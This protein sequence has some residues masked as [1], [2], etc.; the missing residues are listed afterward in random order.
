LALA[1]K[2]DNVLMLSKKTDSNPTNAHSFCC[3]T[4]TLCSKLAAE[5]TWS[6]YK[7]PNCFS[8]SD[9]YSIGSL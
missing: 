7:C 9:T 6:I 5:I 3:V 1:T 2:L 8:W 4:I